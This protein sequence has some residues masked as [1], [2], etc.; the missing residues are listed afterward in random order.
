MLC[1]N[2]PNK[3]A[4][5]KEGTPML[6]GINHLPQEWSH[7]KFSAVFKIPRGFCYLAVGWCP[8]YYCGDVSLIWMT[9]D[10]H[11]MAFAT[12]MGSMNSTG[13]GEM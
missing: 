6:E 9:D 13:R 11:A 2:L 12:Q 3:D 10:E 7:K 5:P 4:P 1:V 8:T